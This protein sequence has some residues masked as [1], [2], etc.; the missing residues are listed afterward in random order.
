M[1]LCTTGSQ[2]S[3]MDKIQPVKTRD[4]DIIRL[5]LH[6]RHTLIS[7][8][9]NNEQLTNQMQLQFY[10]HRIRLICSNQTGLVL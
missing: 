8:V 4:S 2:Y 1:T 7:Y 10:V 9:I 5:E 6:S 3:A